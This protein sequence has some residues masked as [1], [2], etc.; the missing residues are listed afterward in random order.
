MS[1]I[2][3][4]NQHGESVAAVSGKGRVR[5]YEREYDKGTDTEEKASKKSTFANEKEELLRAARGGDNVKRFLDS[6]DVDKNEGF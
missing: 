1:Y 2:T 5:K 6:L 3:S 4:T